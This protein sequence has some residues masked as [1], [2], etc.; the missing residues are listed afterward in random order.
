MARGV[1]RKLAIHALL[2]AAATL[3]GL[4]LLL[5]VQ[6]QWLIATLSRWSPDVLWY[7]E[8]DEPVVALT[9]DDGPDPAT[10][11]PILQLLDEYDARATFFLIGE[12]IPGN[13]QLISQ[14]LEAGHELGNHLTRDERSIALTPAEFQADVAQ[15]HAMLLRFAQP[16]WLRPAG[17]WFNREI[18]SAARALGYRV[19]LGSIYPYDAT[20]PFPA[21]A[22][23]HVIRRARPGSI[24]VLHDS[25]G[26]GERTLTALQRILPELRRRGYRLVTLSELVDGREGY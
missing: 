5:S 20:L 11:P 8:A 4:G 17:G 10:T 1:L 3:L 6:P 25:G 9:I 7:V 21:Y 18:V 23:S 19:A 15:A 2:V 13:E 24:I 14:I 16:R 26:R 12:R 22:A